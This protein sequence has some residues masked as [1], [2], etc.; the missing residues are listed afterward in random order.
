MADKTS[1]ARENPPWGGLGNPKQDQ[2]AC[3]VGLLVDLAG[4]PNHG[5][6]KDALELLANLDHRGARGAEQGTGDG[7]GILLQKPHLFFRSQCPEIGDPRDYAVGQVFFSQDEVMR[8]AFIK[9]IERTAVERH[10]EIVSWRH[11]PTVNCD[12]GKTA[13]ESQPYIMQFFIRPVM[14]SALPLFESK[15][16]LLRR[17]IEFRA[18]SRLG[19]SLNDFYICSLDIETIVYKGMLTCEQLKHYYLDL[20]DERVTS[21]FAM[22][23]S[24]FSTNTLGEWHLAH[25]CRRVVHNGEFNTLRGN[26]NWMRAR[27]A[28]LASPLFEAD[29]DLVKPVVIPDGSDTAKF[30]NVLELLLIAGRTLPAALRMMIPEAW[31]NDPLMPQTKKDYY[32]YHSTIMEPWDGPALVVATDGRHIAAISDRNGFRP[33]RYCVT[34]DDRFVMASE[35]GVLDLD[36]SSIKKKGRLKPGQLLVVDSKTGR[37]FDEDIVLHDLADAKYGN[38]LKSH[39]LRLPAFPPTPVMAA[40]TDH[41]HFHDHLRRYRQLFGYTQESLEYLMAPMAE[42][43]KDPLGSMGDDVPLVAI[44]RQPKVLAN[45]FLQLFAQ[46]SNPPLDFLRETLVTSLRSHI[47]RQRNILSSTPDHCRQVLLESPILTEW[48]LEALK[49]IDER[50]IRAQELDATFIHSDSLE[51]GIE[52]LC[53]QAVKAIDSHIEILVISD[54]KVAAERLPIPSLLAIGAVHHTLIREGKRTRCGIVMDV[55]DAHTV[56]H[57]CTLIGYGADAVHPWLAFQTLDQMV[58]RNEVEVKLGQAHKYYCNA[59]KGGL[60]KVMSKMGISTLQGYK[61]AQI[62]EVVGLSQSLVEQYFPGTPL[63]LPG[64][65]LVTLEQRLRHLHKE[66]FLP[67][68]IA[69]LPLPWGGD[70][71][72]RRDGEQHHWNPYTIAKLQQAARSNDSSAYSAFVDAIRKM[73]RAGHSIRSLMDFH[74]PQREQISLDEVEPVSKILTRFATGSM[75][76]GALSLEAHEALAVAMNQIGAMSGT[77]EGGEQADRFNTSRSCSMKQIASGR[78]GVN[79]DYL[80]AATQIEIKMAQGSKPGEGGELPGNKVDIGIAEVRYSTPGVGLIS[81]PPH[82]DIYSIEDLAQL[83]FDLKCANPRAEIHVKLVARAGVGTIAAGVAKARADSILIS[84]GSGGTGASIMTSIKSAG[85]PW[86]LGL[87]ET[88]QILLANQLRSRIRLRV[89]G[90]LKTGR[91]VVIAALLGAEEFGFGTAPLVALGCIMLRKCHCNTCTVGIATQDPRLRARFNGDAD[92]IVNYL[93]FVAADV[94]EHM[95]LLGFRTMDEMIGRVDKLTPGPRCPLD[96][97]RILYRPVSGDEPYRVRYQDHGID[98]QIEHTI[99]ARIDPASLPTNPLCLKMKITNRDRTFGAL[100]SHHVTRLKQGTKLPDNSIHIYCDGHAGQSFGAFLAS[101]ITLQLTGDANDYVGKSL[102]GG[103]ISICPPEDVQYSPEATIIIGN[104]TLYG[105]TGG[106]LYINGQAGE[107]FA[108][109]NS[110]AYSVVEGIGDHG[111]EYMTGGVVVVLGNTGKNFAAGMSGGEAYVLDESGDFPI[112][113]NN[114]SVRLDRLTGDRDKH[115]VHSLLEK[116]FAATHSTKAAELLKHW[117]EY[118]GRFTRVVPVMYEKVIQKALVEGRDLRCKPP[119]P[120]GD[121]KPSATQF[122]GS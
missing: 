56:H 88:Q 33:C 122:G 28:D 17:I 57:F 3:G 10:F 20:S 23:H 106:E 100:I 86:E 4:R 52:K 76:F 102:S 59:I 103:I 14:P 58:K 115:L 90:G 60:L 46:V 107:R 98:E 118:A 84:G 1:K 35:A 87:A 45:F 44:S 13:C 70:F 26:E 27:Q 91:D 67:N 36:E 110:G 72:W 108:V 85:L 22:V 63:H 19:A 50:H 120:I 65:G 40:A 119:S 5:V 37:V 30:D 114:E 105:A 94:R 31:E 16:Y 66:S 49:N 83:I 61:G 116:H 43:G 113:T 68:V 11:V 47:G 41:A 32:D 55:A 80:T 111:C 18:R 73:D 101:G 54:R 39:R 99:L 15:L 8:G 104:V 95:A 64:I 6:I 24:R 53:E 93:R 7:A 74:A 81:P 117:D 9:L 12:L 75:S 71:S 109:R 69:K 97:S 34:E 96:L 82:H 21:I 79:I 62:F 51:Q 29:V 48:E 38:W 89:D 92:H 77:G 42:Q 2:A 112:K 25:P 121:F 78:F